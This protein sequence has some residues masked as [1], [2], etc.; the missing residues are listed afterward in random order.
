MPNVQVRLDQSKN[1][2]L[3][4]RRG[5]G[6]AFTITVTD[7]ENGLPY[8]VS[9][10]GFE[11]GVVQ[12]YD[13]DTELFTLE[14]ASAGGD[15][16]ILNGGDTG[17]I[18]IDPTN[19]QVDLPEGSYEWRFRSTD[20]GTPNTW[21][22]A[23]FTINNGPLPASALDSISLIVNLG[24]VNVNARINLGSS[25]GEHYRGEVDLAT[26]SQLDEFPE[27]GGTNDMKATGGRP[28]RGDWYLTTSVCYLLNRDEVRVEVP[29]HSML[30]YTGAN[31][32]NMQLGANWKINQ[33]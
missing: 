27:E 11:F 7:E 21:F 9:D 4:Y 3:I 23:P 16:A 33:G 32:G 31:T 17:V 14:E 8:N 6:R 26:S 20:G 28:T 29:P 18:T 12:V 25:T 22:S 15:G 10:F 24:P 2:E 1:A 13:R 19:D 5:E 30:I